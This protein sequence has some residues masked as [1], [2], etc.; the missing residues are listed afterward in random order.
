[1]LAREDTP[2]DKRLVAYVVTQ[3]A[4]TVSAEALRSFVAQRLPGYIVPSAVVLLDDLSLTTN[5]K[6]DRRALATLHPGDGV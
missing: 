1:M 4:V 6:L 2:G 5:G 3:P